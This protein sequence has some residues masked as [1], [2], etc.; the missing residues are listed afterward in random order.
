MKCCTNITAVWNPKNEPEGF[1][2]PENQK[3]LSYTICNKGIADIEIDETEV[4]KSEE[5]YPV[6]NH[7]GY[8]FQ[9]IIKLKALTVGSVKVHIRMTIEV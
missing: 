7:V 1:K 2:F 4:L 3:V 8:Y 9:G 6:E 5:S